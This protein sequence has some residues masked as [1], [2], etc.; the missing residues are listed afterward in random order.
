M[1][2]T[3]LLNAELYDPEPR[4]RAHLLLGG[5]R[6][7]WVGRDVPVVGVPVAEQDLEGR[8]VIPGLIDCHVHL[9]GGGGEAGPE[10]RVPPL[11]L[12]RMTTGGV[13]TAVGVLFAVIRLWARH[14]AAPVM[15]H[16][17]TNSFAYV[18]ALIVS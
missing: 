11:A 15:T 4:G 7:L 2:L 5:G 17:A 14:L 8:P 1:S 3:L 6:V 16:T 13:T 9:T 10:T 12:S 18:A